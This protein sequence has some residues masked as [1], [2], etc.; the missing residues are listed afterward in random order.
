MDPERWK[1]VDDLLQSAL[2]LSSGERGSFLRQ[3]CG[4]DSS[5]EEDVQSLLVS[6]QE[7][8]GFLERPAFELVAES[9]ADEYTKTSASEASAGKSI[10]PYRLLKLV[11]AGGMGEVWK[12]EQI[13]PIRRTVAL[14]LIKAGMDTKAV[15]ARF[16]SERQALAMMDHPSIA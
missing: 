11:G 9:L 15:V 7:I 1:R 10:G 12:A 13:A 16:D 4:G 3:A 14:K 2:R 5:L 8:D 6:Q